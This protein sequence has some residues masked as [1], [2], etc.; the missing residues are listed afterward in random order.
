MDIRYYGD[1][2]LRQVAVSIATID[3]EIKQLAD[4]LV[5]T[6]TLKKGYGLAAPQIGV[7]KRL[8]F[9]DVEDYFEIV[10]NPEIT[11]FD[12]EKVLGVEGCLSIPGAEA[13]VLRYKTIRYA[14]KTLEGSALELEAHDLLARVIQHEVDHLN[15]IL[16]IDHLGEA[17]RLQLLK[18]FERG[19]R[20]T[21]KS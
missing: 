12:E 5:R 11:W 20:E 2:V 21:P 15:G 16:F 6:L 18:E 1:P 13:E 19:R 8:I 4:E 17:K 10:V 9:L 14:G 7:S 3:E